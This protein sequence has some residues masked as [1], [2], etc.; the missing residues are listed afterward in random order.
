[1]L[2]CPIIDAD[3]DDLIALALRP[4]KNWWTR[5]RHAALELPS[6]PL[7]RAASLLG[8][9][10]QAAPRL[11]VHDLLDLVLHEGD[12]LARYARTSS[13]LVRGQV[14]GNI[15]AFTELALNLD[16]GRYPSLPK[17]IDALRTL[18]NAADSDAPDEANID[19]SMDAVRIL[20]IHSAKGLEAPIVVLLDANHSDPAR[21][22]SG[23]L[24]DWP[25]DAG[26]PTHFSVFGRQA[27]RGA[28]RDALFAAEEDFKTQEDWNLLYVAITR[29]KELLIVSG[30]AGAKNVLPGGVVDGSWYARLQTAQE[31]QPDDARTVS[32]AVAAAAET[33]FSLP[34]FSPPVLPPQL[35]DTEAA[36][37]TAAIDEGIALH[38]LLER[39]TQA[40]AWPIGMPDDESIARW[41]PCTRVQAAAVR[42]QALAI[43]AQPELE[44][45]FNPAHYRFAR[46]EMEVVDGT[47]LLR[48]DRVTV[49][50][51][52]VWILDYKRNFLDSERA[53]YHAQLA[54]YRAAAQIVFP[55]KMVRTA[56][57]TVDGRLWEVT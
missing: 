14:I 26:A 20:T 37:R 1:V 45:F 40:H 16:A 52:E 44:R 31:L 49:F 8:K 41:L 2:K 24:C 10:L 3:D 27:E 23:V 13:P 18:Q 15:E 32:A 43:L 17:F 47:E 34:I 30:V 55:D 54:R 6:E 29:A 51:R 11:P 21:D 5:V 46:N 56:L 50:E 33:E 48:F 42:E 9:W 25:Q 38:A 53:A 57:I 7:R 19:A 12:L 28:A 39:L 36:L 22:D 35:A 4:E